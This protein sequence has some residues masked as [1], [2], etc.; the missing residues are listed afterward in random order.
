MPNVAL[1]TEDRT[2]ATIAINRDLV[3]AIANELATSVEAAVEY[4][5]SE[6][7]AVLQDSNLSDLERSQAIEGVIARY[8]YLTGKSDLHRRVCKQIN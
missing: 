7:E 3:D 5:M 4:W 6:F 2:M 1:G 8:K